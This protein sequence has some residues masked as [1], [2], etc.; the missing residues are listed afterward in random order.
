MT[1]GKTIILGKIFSFAPKHS[2]CVLIGIN[3]LHLAI[4]RILLMDA[5]FNGIDL[6]KSGY[7]ENTFLFFP[8]N[9]KYVVG[10]Y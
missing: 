10:T 3:S 7:Q 4:L 5:Y 9:M 1:Q 2:L 8:Q 6:D